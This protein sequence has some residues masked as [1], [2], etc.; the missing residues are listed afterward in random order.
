MTKWI[1]LHCD[2]DTDEVTLTE[3]DR[4]DSDAAIAALNKAER[5]K[6]PQ[7][8]VVL[9]LSEGEEAATANSPRREAAAAPNF[10]PPLAGGDA[11]GRG[12]AT[13]E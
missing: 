4:E 13:A 2:H 7:D 5:E 10:L 9:F 1:L 6:R 12:G 11:A 3:F 8:E